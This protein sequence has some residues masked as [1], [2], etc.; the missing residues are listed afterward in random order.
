MIAV[1]HFTGLM[2]VNNVK[3][4]EVCGWV[5]LV[6]CVDSRV[7]YTDVENEHVTYL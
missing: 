2:T 5:N 6:A 3:I 1:G 4:V 7:V